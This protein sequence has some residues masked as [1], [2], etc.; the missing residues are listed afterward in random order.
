M[1][2]IQRVNGWGLNGTS[3]GNDRPRISA[4]VTLPSDYAP[5]SSFTVK[6]SY[7]TVDSA[8]NVEFDIYYGDVTSLNNSTCLL[9]TSRCV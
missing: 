4:T 7:G 1:P 9:Y 6:V 2:Q 8:N 3:L 5:G